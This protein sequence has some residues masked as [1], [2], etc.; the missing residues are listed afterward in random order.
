MDERKTWQ[1]D[2]EEKSELQLRLFLLELEWIVDRWGRDYGEDL[3]IRPFK[4]GIR[5]GHDF[6]IQL[7]GTDDTDQYKLKTTDYYSYSVDLPNL[8]Q[9]D[10]V[11]FPV[12][13]VLWDITQNVGYWA[14]M[15]FLISNFLKK[16]PNWLENLS[17]A[18]DPTRK[19]YIPCSQILNQEKIH[20]MTAMIEQ[21]YEKITLAK[22]YIE[23]SQRKQ[24]DRI[25][26]NLQ[27]N[28]PPNFN[29]ISPEKLPRHIQQQAEIAAYQA[30]TTQN[31]QNLN[32]W[33]ELSR[34]YYE[35]GEM[36][37]ALAAINKAWDINRTDLYVVNARACTLAEY[38][39]TS[40]HPKSM[41]YEAIELFGSIRDQIHPASFFYNVGNCYSGLKNY[42]KAIENF[43]QGLS[44]NPPPDLAAQIWKNRGTA[45][46]N[47]E[48]YDEEENS[49]KEA[50]RL[51][52]QLWEAYASW[53]G[54]KALTGNYNQASEL[55]EKAFHV[56]PN[57]E[58]KGYPQLYWLAYSLAG[59]GDLRSAYLRINQML[60]I[61]PDNKDGLYLKE[62]IL[63]DLWR[64]DP[65]YKNSA[66]VFYKERILD[67]SEDSF[68]RNELH[69]IYASE[70]FEDEVI[71]LLEAGE[72]L[73]QVTVE[74]IYRY[75]LLLE[76]EQKIV[77]ATLCLEKAVERAQDHHIIHALARMKK[78]T[79]NYQDAIKYYNLAL[80]DVS[81]PF[82]I[83]R[84]ISDCCYFLDN[85]REAAIV[86]STSILLGSDEIDLWRNL[87]YALD[88]LGIPR[89]QTPTF[90]T[91][92]TE[93]MILNVTRTREDIA[94]KLDE[95]ILSQAEN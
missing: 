74:L 86:L 26:D 76:A 16:D 51:N 28:F 90:F 19:I 84:A 72:G 71:H 70:D 73:S 32:A 87:A 49:Y 88:K 50:L 1:H 40:S 75:A 62:R 42:E 11:Q 91:Y 43:D 41:L 60:S 21:E 78:K 29:S 27:S 12:I 5:T 47:L 59:S 81:N 18:K 30:T 93:S 33:I 69:L 83:L 53:G 66:I 4:D 68:A 95:M 8:R 65:I 7:K 45:F 63:S 2:F 92:L 3:F 24:L 54:T 22:K 39:M 58:V 85:Y 57:L 46:H 36:D 82:P 44:T 35:L 67:N 52:P 80:Q 13:F 31:P 56:N 37:K 17:E 89:H 38:A 15:Q 14:H 25:K 61:T 6:Y 23:E 10:R 55:L 94:D 20:L 77:Q 64:N 79:C 48:K 9:W 34:V